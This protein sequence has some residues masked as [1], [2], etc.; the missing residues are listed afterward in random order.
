MNTGTVSDNFQTRE[1]AMKCWLED[2]I[3]DLNDIQKPVEAL[4]R[5]SNAYIAKLAS[6]R[7]RCAVE[8]GYKCKKANRPS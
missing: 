7:R 1:N 4:W 3:G 8:S 2:E 6:V 5:R